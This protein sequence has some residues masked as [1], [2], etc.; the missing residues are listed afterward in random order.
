MFNK[1]FNEKTQS[2]QVAAS[3]DLTKNPFLRY[4]KASI[5]LK[6]DFASKLM[7]DMSIQPQLRSD[8]AFEFLLLSD[9]LE[10]FS[11]A[12][13]QLEVNDSTTAV[14]ILV[15]VTGKSWEELNAPTVA[16][17]VAEKTSSFLDKALGK[18][19]KVATKLA[20]KTAK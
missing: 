14:D 1:V 11:V 6:M 10:V 16:D 3:R 15:A 5:E 9:A 19:N 8:K 2:A 17:K 13:D 4:T 20:E 12:G 18:L 7:M